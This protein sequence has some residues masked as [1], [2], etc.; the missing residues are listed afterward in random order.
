MFLDDIRNPPDEDW[1]VVRNF[2][3]AIA[4]IEDNGC[5]NFISFDHDLGDQFAKTGYDLAKWLVETDLDCSGFL[6]EDF[7][8]NVHSANPVGAANIRALLRSY[9]AQR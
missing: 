6:P 3:E 9:L 7:D 4:H 5:P 8:F 2:D 1:V